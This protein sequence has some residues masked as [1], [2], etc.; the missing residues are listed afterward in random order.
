MEAK[1][2]CPPCLSTYDK[3]LTIPSSTLVPFTFFL[4]LFSFCFWLSLNHLFFHL[5]VLHNCGTICRFPFF[6]LSQ[7]ATATMDQNNHCM[8][9]ILAFLHACEKNEVLANVAACW[10]SKP[11]TKERQTTIANYIQAQANYRS[12][13]TS[14]ILRECCLEFMPLMIPSS[15]RTIGI[16]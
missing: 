8:V 9:D 3:G 13:S 11:M 12:S 1:L 14:T 5:L 10:S 15:D 16:G 4:C 6:L 7:H 2:G